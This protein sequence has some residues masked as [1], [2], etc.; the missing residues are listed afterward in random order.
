MLVH[1]LTE[2]F[3]ELKYLSN[4]EIIFL[5]VLIRLYSKLHGCFLDTV[6][7]EQL[8]LDKYKTVVS[9]EG[10]RRPGGPCQS[11]RHAVLRRLKH[12][13]LPT[14]HKASASA[15]TAAAT[16]ANGADYQMV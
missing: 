7:K 8:L 11:W 2:V 10:K 6:C 13:N 5:H 15:A 16:T 3:I 1:A 12:C 14:W 4:T 9:T